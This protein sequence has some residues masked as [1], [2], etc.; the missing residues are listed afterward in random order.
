MK[1]IGEGYNASKSA[2]RMNMRT[3]ERQSTRWLPV[4]TSALLSHQVHAQ[5]DQSRPQSKGPV[6]CHIRNEASVRDRAVPVPPSDL[7][8]Q[9]EV[10]HVFISSKQ[11]Y[12][13]QRWSRQPPDYIGAEYVSRSPEEQPAPRHCIPENVVADHQR[14]IHHIRCN[15]ISKE[16]VDEGVVYVCVVVC[17]DNESGVKEGEGVG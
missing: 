16:A 5:V 8:Q 15:H 4:I 6:D 11:F 14:F 12:V 13:R 2:S 9:R 7:L 1:E 10:E 17:E 3:M